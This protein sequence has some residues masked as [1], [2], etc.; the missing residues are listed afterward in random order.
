MAES[1]TAP[2]DTQVQ[3]GSCWCGA[4][5]YEARGAPAFVGLCHCADC[6]K[7]SGSTGIYY[8]S[9]RAGDFAVTA[10]SDGYTTYRGRSFCKTCGSRLFSGYGRNNGGVDVRLGSLDGAPCHLVPLRED[11]VRRRELWF[12]QI[13]GAGQAEED[14]E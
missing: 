8:G 3:T 1:T 10:G 4:V 9:W 12:K 14:P 2:A 6:R 5:R 11:W 7:E 13:D